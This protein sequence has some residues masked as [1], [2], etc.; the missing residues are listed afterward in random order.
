[1]LRNAEHEILGAVKEPTSLGA[2][3]RFPA[4][5]VW[6]ATWAAAIVSDVPIPMRFA[7]SLSDFFWISA[8][9]FADAFERKHFQGS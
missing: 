3:G 9:E 5:A 1:M 7:L 8:W 6:R 4:Y 2:P